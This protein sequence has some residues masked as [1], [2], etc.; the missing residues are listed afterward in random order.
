MSIIPVTLAVEG[1]TDIPVARRILAHL[2]LEVAV[3][4]ERGGKAGLDSSLTGY[5]RAAAFAPWLVLRDLNHDAPC[6]SELIHRLL[7]RPA[8][9]MVFRVPVRETEAW[10]LADREELARYLGVSL[11]KVPSSPDLLEDPKLSLINLAR[12]SDKRAI[13]EDFV[14]EE[15]ITSVVGPG[16][17]ARIIEYATNHWRPN[18]AADVSPSLARCLRAL[19]RF[20]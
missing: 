17:V 6:A 3:I 2:G 8:A 14:P 20:Q 10:L 13:R 12:R 19:A 7:P 18:A 1:T 5:N 9:Q 4:Y 15:G 16:Y 11:S